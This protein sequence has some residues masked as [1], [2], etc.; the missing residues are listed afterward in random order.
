MPLSR[1]R[2]FAGMGGGGIT[3]NINGGYYLSEDVARDLG[4]KIIDML[5][6]NRK[7]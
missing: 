6:L 4:G 1:L 2:E 5:K 7:L 3:V